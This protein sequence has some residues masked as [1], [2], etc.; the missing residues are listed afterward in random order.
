MPFIHF[1]ICLQPRQTPEAVLFQVRIR[2]LI[3]V[4]TL[5]SLKHLE[6]L[7]LLDSFSFSRQSPSLPPTELLVFLQIFI[8]YLISAR[9]HSR[10][11]EYINEK[12]QTALTLVWLSCLDI[13][14]RS[15]SLLVPFPVRAQDW[16]VGSVSSTWSGTFERKA[17]D[18]VSYP[19][20]LPAFLSL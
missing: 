15:K 18:D 19:L 11:L 17:I 16:V 10:L 9:Q 13:I 5:T 4:L 20:F 7:A 8:E 1:I 14:L 3:P 12:K 6:V 2:H